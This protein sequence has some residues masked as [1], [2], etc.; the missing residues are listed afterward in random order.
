MNAN[1]FIDTNV[2]V[3]SFDLNNQ[4][5]RGKA[6]SIIKNALSDGRGYISIQVIQEFFNVATEKFKSPMPV[7]A[8]K[9]YLEKVGSSLFQVGNS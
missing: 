6:K 8:A 1:Y 2:F 4:D 9:E 7:L 3:Y 5:K